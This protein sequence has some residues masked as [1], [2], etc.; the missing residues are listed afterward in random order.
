M[1][2]SNIRLNKLIFY[3]SYTLIIFSTMFKQV[4]GINNLLETLS[5][6]GIMLLLINCVSNINK[7]NI[8]KVLILF[9]SVL[10]AVITKITSKSNTIF[11]LILLI[12]AAKNIKL[13]ELIKYDLKIKIPFMIII[14]VLY[15]LRMTDVNLHYRN[16]IIRHSMGFSNPNVF[17]TYILAI[18]VEYLYLRRKK[19]NAKDLIIIIIGIFIIDFYA[20][21][22]TQI[23]CLI[24]LALIVYI[25]KYTGKKF[26]NNSIVNFIV[27]N[28]FIILTIFSLLIIYFYGQGNDIVQDIDVQT[29]GRI[30]QISGVFNEYD[31]N[32]FGNKL[33]LVTSL[34]AK[35]TGK[36]QTALDN[37][38]IYS[39]LSYGI[40]PF[41]IMCIAMKKYMKTTI[42]ENEDILRTIML[43][44]LIGGLMERFCIEVQYNIFLLYFSYI[45]YDNKNKKEKV[46]EE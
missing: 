19:V 22:R 38:Y 9:I 30:K 11:I 12:I 13:E 25:N 26:L 23:F 44:F 29:S 18:I 15:F 39:L 43:V 42:K 35:L 24:I 20:D 27:S 1:K 10:M 21:S 41:I 31:V 4:T 46:L 36:Q 2:N 45:I 14:V 8:N 7:L 5:T 34:Q 33:D 3:V 16:G 40:I 6:I 28:I 32:L 37:V 17:S